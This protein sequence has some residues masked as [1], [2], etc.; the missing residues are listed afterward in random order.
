MCLRW[1]LTLYDSRTLHRREPQ[2]A[3]QKWRVFSSD[4]YSGTQLALLDCHSA[5][6]W[7]VFHLTCSLFQSLRIDDSRLFSD[8]VTLRKSIMAA[9]WLFCQTGPRIIFVKSDQNLILVPILMEHTELPYT[10]AIHLMMNIP[11]SC[12]ST[13]S[14][15]L[16]KRITPGCMWIIGIVS[17]LLCVSDIDVLLFPRWCNIISHQRD[18]SRCHP[19]WSCIAFTFPGLDQIGQCP[20]TPYSGGPTLNPYYAS[21]NSESVSLPSYD[22]AEDNKEVDSNTGVPSSF[23]GHFFSPGSAKGDLVTGLLAVPLVDESPLA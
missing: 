11:R 22:I 4:H 23:D 8:F 13:K 14:L 20:P 2:I 21:K 18:G 6:R 16:G 10:Q 3:W 12:H 17:K 15:T 1:V 7:F 9:L 19:G 5:P